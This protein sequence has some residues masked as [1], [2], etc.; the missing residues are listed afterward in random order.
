M[1]ILE[2]L[3]WGNEGSLEEPNDNVEEENY[4]E[5]F[6]VKPTDVGTSDDSTKNSEETDFF[7]F[8]DKCSA[9]VEGNSDS[10]IS[11]VNKSEEQNCDKHVDSTICDKKHINEIINEEIDKIEPSSTE[12][13]RSDSEIMSSMNNNIDKEEANANKSCDL[14]EN[15]QEGQKISEYEDLDMFNSYKYWYISPE[16][17]LDL[18]IIEPNNSRLKKETNSSSLTV[19][20]NITK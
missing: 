11:Q 20:S 14:I 2:Q 10:L 13:R 7:T 3:S 18:D 17:P 4:D 1:S 15:T 8:L 12:N 5:E 19:S 16:M 6:F 9:V